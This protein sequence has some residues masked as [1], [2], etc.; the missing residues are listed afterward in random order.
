MPTYIALLRAVNVGGTGK[1]AMSDLRDLC[2]GIGLNNPRT[3]LQ[4]GNLTFESPARPTA[5]LEKLL[6]SEAAARLKLGSDFNVRA[7]KELDTVIANN[8]LPK[9]AKRD[10]SH[11]LVMFC[12]SAPQAKDVEALQAAIVGRE[13]LKADGRHLYIDYCDGI[14]TSKLTGNI[15]EKELGVRGTMRNWNTVTKLATLAAT[16]SRDSTGMK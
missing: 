12:K 5:A 16:P 6:E 9:S 11:F 2:E 8:P 1:I 15:I 3:L 14:G 10:P 4:S 7:T 13:I